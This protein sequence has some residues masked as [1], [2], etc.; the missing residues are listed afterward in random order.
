MSD[1]ATLVAQLEHA[2]LIGGFERT[3]LRDAAARIAE[4]EAEVA[5]L[6][7]ALDGAL[8]AD[9]SSL[10]ETLARQEEREACENLPVQF[11]I[12]L[13]SA[14]EYMDGWGDCLDAYRAAIRALPSLARE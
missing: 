9:W 3:L 8:V 6:S 10:R 14:P 4:L 11:Q 1:S 5:R 12:P 13:G 7:E 2:A